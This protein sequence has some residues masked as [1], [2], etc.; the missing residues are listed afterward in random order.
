M[1]IA[2]FYHIAQMGLGAFVYQQQIHRLY[3][4]ELIKNSDYIHCGV[5]G[6]QE[7]FNVPENVKIKYNS[8]NYWNTEKETLLDLTEFC[9]ENKDYKILYFHT[10][11]VSKNSIHTNSWRLM[12]EYFVIDKWKECIEYLNEYDCVGAELNTVGPTLWSDGTLTDNDP[13][14][15]YAG[16]FWWA[17]ASYINTIHSKYL[18]SEDRMEKERWIGDG[19]FGCKAKKLY[20]SD[21]KMM[22]NPYTYYFS[23]NSYVS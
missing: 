13:I 5:N 23:E 4:S 20:K 17:N 21:I 12:M 10:K 16:N 19:K 1:K 15:F 9:K 18:E 3:A 11:G 8:E 2:I 22:E 6:N 7:L 14:P